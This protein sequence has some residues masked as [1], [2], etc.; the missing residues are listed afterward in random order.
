MPNDI[1]ARFAGAA[2]PLAALACAAQLAI[3]CSGDATTTPP[4]DTSNT[5]PPVTPPPPPPPAPATLS[6]RVRVTGNGADADGFVISL[7][8]RTARAS[9]SAPA[10]FDS[11]AAGD[12]TLR[13]TDVAPQCAAAADSVKLTAAAGSSASAEFTVD[14]VGGFAWTR[15]DGAIAYLGED[16]R[17]VVVTQG[18]GYTGFS[19]SFSPDG[20]ALAWQEYEAGGP[21]QR[22]AISR[23]DGG[24]PIV[25]TSPP[26][27]A[28]DFQPEW[29]PDGTLVTFT[30]F[31]GSQPG[32]IMAMNPNGS[33]LRA[34]VAPEG[35]VGWASWSPDGQ[36]LVVYATQYGGGNLTLYRADGTYLR[37]LTSLILPDQVGGSIRWT[38]DGQAIGAMTFLQG[39]QGISVVSRAGGALGNL[40]PREGIAYAYAWS[41]DGK[42]AAVSVT[43]E[44]QVPGYATSRLFLV[45]RDGSN[46]RELAPGID[47]SSAAWSADGARIAFT[48]VRDRMT[49]ELMI[50]RPDG[51]GL[52]AVTDASSHA[53]PLWNP[54][55]RPGAGR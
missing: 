21:R 22:V 6:V 38:G 25:Y 15:A 17:I 47:A 34:L 14:C 41:P 48:T 32:A 8:S 5:K 45:N 40:W 9:A 2:L 20:R 24:A 12:V 7:G 19:R 35:T 37:Q 55:A 49:R 31:G 3:A 51:T 30:R 23:L 43:P 4:R 44:P 42:Q 52:R 16:G 10:A 54:A 27:G 28:Q 13:I 46:P 53:A 39:R 29:S 11:V 1:R 26:D 33:G 18:A 36:E 50:V